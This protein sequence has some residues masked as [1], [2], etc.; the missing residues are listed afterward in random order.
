MPHIKMKIKNHRM[1]WQ[2]YCIHKGIRLRVQTPE[3]KAKVDKILALIG[4]LPILIK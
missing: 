1:L 3:E 2:E 4:Q